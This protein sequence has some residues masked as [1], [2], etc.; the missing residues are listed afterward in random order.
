LADPQT[1]NLYTYTRNN[2]LSTTDSDGHCFW[3]LCIGESY[4]AVAITGTAIATVAYLASPA[5]RQ[6]MTS[7]LTS[8]GNGIKNAAD[9]VGRA[10][11]ENGIGAGTSETGAIPT[12]ATPTPAQQGRDAQGKFLPKQPGQSQPG[13]DAEKG[14]LAAEGAT[15]TGTALPGTG[16]KVDGTVTA[17]GQKIEVKSGGSVSNTDQ[18]VQTGQAA[19]DATGRPL[20]VVTT[21]PNVRVFKPAQNNP[22]LQIRPVKQP[23]Q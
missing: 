18:L 8:L 3:D 6:A 7:V 10:V 21:N 22:N 13:A 17:T 12:T 19:K 4:A 20:L 9:E 14:A 15:K 23:P 2:P 16:R 5:G 11:A 1:L